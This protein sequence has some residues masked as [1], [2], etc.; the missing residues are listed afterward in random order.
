VSSR[1]FQSVLL[2]GQ[3]KGVVKKRTLTEKYHEKRRLKKHRFIITSSSSSSSSFHHHQQ[4]HVWCV[5]VGRRTAA[6]VATLRGDRDDG[7]DDERVRVV[8]VRV[9]RRVGDFETF[10]KD[11]GCSFK[12]G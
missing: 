11:N 8:A 12:G 9:G 2:C 5:V 7:R 3:R 4:Q 6:P 1:F 10:E